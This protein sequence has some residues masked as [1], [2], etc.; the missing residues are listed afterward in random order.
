[1]NLIVLLIDN[2]EVEFI[3]AKKNLSNGNRIY[4]ARN[5]EEA[6]NFLQD[7]KPNV[8]LLDMRLENEKSFDLIPHIK[9]IYNDIPIIMITEVPYPGMSEEAARNGAIGVKTKG[10]IGM[11]YIDNVFSTV[12]KFKEFKAR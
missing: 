2:N 6:L 7:A 4:W 12:G 1:M 5:K 3:N 8:I 10:S 9:S 11:K